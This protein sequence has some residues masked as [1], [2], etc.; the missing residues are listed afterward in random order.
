[1][2]LS[3]KVINA[4]VPTATGS[5]GYTGMGFQPKIIF[6]MYPGNTTTGW[7]DEGRMTLGAACSTTEESLLGFFSYDAQ[8]TT[9]TDRRALD[10]ALGGR[11]TNGGFQDEA[12][13]TSFDSDG[14][15]LNWGTV[16]DASGHPGY[17]L[18]LGGDD[19]TNVA[20]VTLTQ[21]VSTGNQA[22]TGVGFQPDLIIVYGARRTVFDSPGNNVIACVGAFDGTNQWCCELY[23]EDGLGTSDTRRTLHTDQIIQ[24]ETPASGAAT[25]EASAVSLDSDG[26]T[27]NWTATSQANV[28]RV[29]CIKCA[30]V[31][32]G[33]AQCP[34]SASEL[35]VS[36]LGFRPTACMFFDPY[37]Q[38]NG[39]AGD[40]L[41][42][43]TG[44]AAWDH[45]TATATQA[46][47]GVQDVDA[48]TTTIANNYNNNNACIASPG[49]TADT[50]VSEGSFLAPTNDGFI[51][52]YTTAGAARYFAYIAFGETPEAGAKM[53]VSRHA[54]STSTGEQALVD[55]NCPDVPKAI[56]LQV[57]KAATDDSDTADVGL[58]IAFVADNGAGGAEGVRTTVIARDAQAT[59]ITGRQTD[60]TSS[61]AILLRLFD[62]SETATD[63][64]AS[65]V[66]LIPGG[67]VINI[68][69]A[70]Y[71]AYL[72]TMTAFWGEEVEAHADLVYPNSTVNLT[73]DVTTPGFEPDVVFFLCTGTANEG[74]SSVLIQ[75][76]GCAVNDGS[77]TQRCACIFSVDGNTFSSTGSIVSTAYVGGQY[78]TSGWTWGAEI[79]TFD[80][81]GFTI[82]TRVAGTGG[83]NI[84]YLAISFGAA[85]VDFSLFSWQMP[86]ATGNYA[87]TGPGHQPYAVTGCVCEPSALDTARTMALLSLVSFDADDIFTTFVRDKHNVATTVAKSRTTDSGLYFA[88]E[89]GTTDQEATFVSMDTTGFTLNYTT[90][91]QTRYGW[92]FSLGEIVSSG[93]TAGQLGIHA[94]E[95]G[96]AG[97]MHGLHPIEA[98]AI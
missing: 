49:A 30:N 47:V 73:Q 85:A 23:S 39:T 31:K 22:V 7:N 87:E 33:V 41:V 8:T 95:Y 19:I 72:V 16:G 91:A 66:R 21:S 4:D 36:G 89:D 27:I 32:V 10:D 63:L 34:A 12:A 57:S 44:F 48:Q 2:A 38:T 54:L 59:T 51:I 35:T 88:D 37:S 29:V 28:Y 61:G 69:D 42:F 70:P 97:L 82:T 76:Y 65:T 52:D 58:C 92:A 43:N 9:N 86:V 96:R 71:S 25:D 5:V 81:S 77:D 93:G 55:P 11:Y 60:E 80:A 14:F 24:F 18:G 3:A 6:T 78:Y 53:G 64:E 98:G 83:D 84:S 40:H 46:T 1:M 79:G 56:I 15:T 68:T 13:F 90:S 75:S 67:V 62:T 45:D 20:V 50:L 17:A 94:I 74:A 26:F